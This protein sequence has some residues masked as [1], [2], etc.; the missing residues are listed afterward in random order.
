[1]EKF[2]YIARNKFGK[3]V[4]GS[5]E[6][7]NEEEALAQL[8]AM[9]LLVLE[10]H[11]GSSH[12]GKFLSAGMGLKIGGRKKKHNGITNNDI[13][14]F[15]R[16]LATLLG[17]G[18]TIL[19]SLETISKQVSSR[20]LIIVIGNLKQ[21]M[22]SG[23]SFH[24]SL[25]KEPAVFSDFWVNLVESGEASGNL[26]VILD[27]LASDLERNAEFR[28]KV[29]SSLIYPIILLCASIFALLFL[30]V[31]IV[32]TFAEVFKSFNLT[33]PVP[34]LILIAVS[35]FVR[36]TSLHFLIGLV[37]GSILFLNY[38]KTKN[39]RRNFE[40]FIFSLPLFGEFFRALLV[41]RFSSELATLIE[42]GMPILYSLEITEKSV[43]SVVMGGIIRSIKEDVR[44]GKPLHASLEKSDF[45]DPMVVQMVSVG[46]EIGELSQMLKRINSFYRDYVQTFLSRFL[47]LF[48][49]FI[50]LFMGVVI[51]FM[52]IGMFLPIFK[53][54]QIS[55]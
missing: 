3:K 54:S 14:V 2:I 35:N 5:F 26:A 37:I 39:G 38:I 28:G 16:Q 40:V 49:P 36:K 41:E 17:A 21:S 6:G 25:A 52:V 44:S 24:E 19:K 12:Q 9:E 33:L 20:K 7:A 15:C 4:T 34:T 42:S 1:V 29:I 22:E 30:T 8:Q 43:G 32:P 51:A 55:G 45:F 48:E 53:I 31:K 18:V 47:S 23:L 50:L 27:R 46:E 11:S 10:I 13:V